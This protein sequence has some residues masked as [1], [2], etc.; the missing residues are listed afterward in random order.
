VW[1]G[2]PN[3]QLVTEVTGRQP[4]RAL[5]VGCGE[6]ADAIWLARQGWTVV[7][8]DISGVALERA[9]EHARDTDPAAAARIT[10]QH[11]DL[12]VQPPEPRSFDLVSAQFMQLPPEPRGRLFTSLAAAV[13]D[14]GLLLVVGHHPSDLTSGVPRPPRP[15]V[16]YVPE[17]IAGLL[18][19]SWTIEVC[20]ARP[21]QA[22]TAEGNEV[23][24]HDTVLLA[25]RRPS[26]PIQRIK[27]CLNGQ[28]AA[29]EHEAVP[30]TPAEVAQAAAAAAAAGAEA[31]HIHPRDRHGAQ[32]LAAE[33]VGAAVIAIRHACPALP[34][35]VTTGLWVADG[36]PAARQQAVTAWAD[37]DR[38]ARPDFA[39][40][41]VGEP[42]VAEL[43]D[44]LRGA[45]IGV[46]AGVWT[47]DDARALAAGALGTGIL[48]IMVEVLGPP[49]ATARA[50]AEEILA[51][52]D[53][54]ALE[55]PRLLHG[56][57]ETCWSLVEYA[58]RLGIATRIGLEDTTT[59][60]DGELI[61]GNAELVMRALRVWDAARS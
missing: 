21:R 24:I 33:D 47:T 52:L 46:E 53:A 59:G 34:V 28:R 30:M 55:P 61:A 11:A 51:V 58:G 31:V 48:R 19:G 7:A 50:R 4:G 10:W 3:P 57:D 23:T 37:L 12:L 20:E 16:F 5:D 56:A 38:A 41:N 60:P 17:E 26:S 13:R 36:D 18:D 14:G 43:A 27:C 42:G 8:A 6:G 32:S 2:N 15:E 54:A 49:A 35:G 39:S 44:T 9:A 29:D 40:I 25:T 22:S 1:S 45:G